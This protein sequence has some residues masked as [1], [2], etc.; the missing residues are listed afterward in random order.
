MEG[1]A[2]EVGVEG[3]GAMKK[4]ARVTP[5]PIGDDPRI[6]WETALEEM[7]RE[8]LVPG[9]EAKKI[10]YFSHEGVVTDSREDIDH[11]RRLRCLDLYCNLLGLYG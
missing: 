6:L 7:I 8:V 11:E 10:V 4:H 2:L 3:Q 5:P 1:M 9:L